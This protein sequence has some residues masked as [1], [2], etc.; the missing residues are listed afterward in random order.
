MGI[1]NDS[2]SEPNLRGRSNSW[3]GDK[4]IVDSGNTRSFGNTGSLGTRV[5][6]N[7]GG[8]S[9]VSSFL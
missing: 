2:S 8:W 7:G 5:K 6:F 9:G 3:K 1:R 4:A